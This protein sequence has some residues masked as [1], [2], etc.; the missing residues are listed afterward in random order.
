MNEILQIRSKPLPWL[1]PLLIILIISTVS[2]AK[3]VAVIKIKYRWAR[4]VAPIVKS[5]LS[6]DGSVTV[7]ERVNSLVIVDNQDAIQRVRDY[8]AQFDIPLEQ[9]R[10]RV[11]FYENR[12]GT[13]GSVQA[14]GRVSG[15][16]WHASVGGR[17]KD[18]A[19]IEVEE[20]RLRRSNFSEQSVIATA[21]QPAYIIA[22]KEIPYH[23]RWPNYSRK[24]GAGA[25]TVVFQTVETGFDVI[26]TIFHEEVLVR[27]VPRIAY[28]DH[29]DAVVHFYG[30]QTQVR[31]PYGEWIEIGG[32]GDQQNEVIKEI[33]SRGRNN[34][35]TS[36]TML[37]M[38]E[39]L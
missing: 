35:R 24:Y 10:I 32:T 28:D 36:M 19:D 23:E 38:A 15:D 14:R 27:I 33:L 17:R 9:V 29:K 3:D 1:F 16:D 34:H 21:G 26:P 31:V 11:R 20:S 18:G 37:M 5:M 2:L 7:S 8:L 30:A 12:V 39:K 4:E 22:G 25:A 13:E 6:T